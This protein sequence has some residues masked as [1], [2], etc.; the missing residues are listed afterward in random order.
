MEQNLALM[1]EVKKL[2][3]DQGNKLDIIEDDIVKI[4]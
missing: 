3:H 2:I 4:Y 1:E